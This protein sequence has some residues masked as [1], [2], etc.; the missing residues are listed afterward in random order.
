VVP[1][2]VR[3]ALRSEP[4]VVYGD[5]Q[6]T[7]CFTNVRDTVQAVV[8]LM[9]LPAATGEIFNIGQRHEVRILDLARLVIALTGSASTV[10]LVGYDDAAAYGERAAGFEDM[11][12][13][14]PDP[15]KLRR[16]TGFSPSIPL[17][18]TLREII[19]HERSLQCAASAAS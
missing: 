17:E 11:R 9:E 16:Y 14:V 4:L 7:R 3:W 6:Q 10:K 13:R 8:A 5:G 15:S 1:R 18:E 12:R 19:A 2:F